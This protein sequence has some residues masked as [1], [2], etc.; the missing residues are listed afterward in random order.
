MKRKYLVA[1]GAGFIGSH[2]VEALLREKAHVVVLDDFSSGCIHNL[3]HLRSHEG[4]KIVKCDI[5]ERIPNLGG[6]N[7]VFHLAAEA[8]PTDYEKHPMNCLEVNSIGNW[9]LIRIARQSNARYIF[10]SSSEVYGHHDPL[11]SDGLSE[12]CSSHLILH[13]KRSPYFIGK[14]YGEELVKALCQH[15]TI[16]YLIIRP[17]NIYGPRMDRKTSYGRVI[18][19]FLSWALHDEPLQINGDGTQE[20]SFCHID[21]FISCIL[22]VIERPVWD[23]RIL[24]IGNPEPIRIIDLARKILDITDS[25]SPYLHT[26]RY[27]Y[28]PKYRTP[29][30][31]RAREWL[32][33]KPTTCLEEGILSLLIYE[34]CIASAHQ[35]ET[36]GHPENPLVTG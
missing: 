10:F 11:P 3:D 29:N 25:G 1:G 21:D 17:F 9:N 7:D 22:R 33:W 35:A 13:R 2:L 18:P 20:R 5:T 4:L 36:E 12:D 27:E 19:N 28:E 26:Q 34:K 32:G 30:I 8:N 14:V 24:N 15:F 23:H 16:P 31:D 6:F